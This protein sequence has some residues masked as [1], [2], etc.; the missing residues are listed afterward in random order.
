MKEWR[1]QKFLGK[2]L[3]DHQLKEVL[4]VGADRWT[5]QQMIDQ[6]HCGNF[7]AAAAVTKARDEEGVRDVKDAMRPLDV[8]ALLRHRGIGETACYVWL[9]VLS[10]KGYDVIEWVDQEEPRSIA[11]EIRFARNPP[12]T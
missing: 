9:C 12:A 2:H 1:T 3:I 4:R 5:R 10:Y 8:H 11:P 6:L 7:L